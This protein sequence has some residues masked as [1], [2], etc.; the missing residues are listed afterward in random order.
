MFRYILRRFA[1]SILTL[2]AS[3]VIVF[4]LVC[5]SGDPLGELRMNPHLSHETLL[6]RIHALH[7][8]KSIPVRYWIWF[9]GLLHGSLGINLE[10]Q[11]IRSGIAS[12]LQI[13]LRMVVVATLLAIVIAVVTGV[14]AAVR[15]GGILDRSFSFINFVLLA[16]PTFVIGLVLKLYVALP[17]NQAA[18]SYVLPVNGSQSPTLT[19]SFWHRL[20]DYAIHMLM[21]TLTL[22][23]VSYSSWAIYQRSSFLEAMDMDHVRLARSKGLSPRRVLVRHILRNAMIPV[24]TVVAL[25]FA[26]ILGGAI[27]TESVYSWNGMGHWFI[28]AVGATDVYAMVAYLLITALF[29]IVFN[30]LTDVAYAI[31]D[32]RIRYA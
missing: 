17:I 6:L 30:L 15:R 31:L 8:D 3:T 24:V 20:P 5:L 11:V 1:A 10:G 22:T 23:L 25:D 27:I 26:G 16:T 14:L 12:A 29:I 18:G 32:P 13:T 21:P 28:S 7:L 4:W 2:W 19:G 9:K